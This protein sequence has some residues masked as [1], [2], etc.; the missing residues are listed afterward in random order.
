LSAYIEHRSN[1]NITRLNPG[2]EAVGM[3]FGFHL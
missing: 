1:A 3:N 2:I